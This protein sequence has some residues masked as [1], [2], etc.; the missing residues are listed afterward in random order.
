MNVNILP[1][2]LVHIIWT[3]LDNTIIKMNLVRIIIQTNIMVE[4]A[5][6][7]GEDGEEDE[8]MGRL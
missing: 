6:A 5:K 8:E 2:I 7:H 4:E 1:T 3:N